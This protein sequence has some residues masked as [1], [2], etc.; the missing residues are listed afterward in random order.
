MS[1]VAVTG[2]RGSLGS[3]IVPRLITAG[4][5]VLGID[6]TECP[7][8]T[9]TLRWQQ[10]DLARA[11]PDLAGC[12]AVVHLAGVPLEADWATLRAAN[13]DATESVLRA[14]RIHG[15]NRIVLASSIHATG[16]TPVPAPGH[17]VPADVPA[18]PNTLYGVSK[19]AMEALARMY[20]DRWGI[21]VVCLRIAS[22]FDHPRDARMKHTWL[23]PADAGRLVIAA[24]ST[25]EPG[26]RMVWGV[27]ANSEAWL[28]GAEGRS[29]A[30]L[31]HDDAVTYDIPDQAD[32][33]PWDST[34][35]GLFSSPH[36]PS[37]NDPAGFGHESE[38]REP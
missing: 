12:D 28:S 26:F 24:L 3:D 14:M 36:P 15:V 7:A 13:V 21:D 23:S 11:L 33:Q 4:Y 25:P 32:P 9:G 1:T 8:D 29:I 35:G 16:F 18:R 20:H 37:M 5:D 34:I 30:Y 2:A 27:S 19:V 6:R 38:G 31:P 17:L 10:C 22:R